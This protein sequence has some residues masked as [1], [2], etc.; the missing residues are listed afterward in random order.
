VSASVHV[1]LLCGACEEEVHVPL[2]WIDQRNGAATCTSC[3]MPGQV[4]VTPRRWEA[5]ARP[6]LLDIGAYR[7]EP[8]K[9]VP[10]TRPS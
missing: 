7:D 1:R 9:F 8:H 6:S 2:A 10:V 4:S 5:A 3:G